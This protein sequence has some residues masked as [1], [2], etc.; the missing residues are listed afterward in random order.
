MQIIVKN[1][2]QGLIIFRHTTSLLNEIILRFVS[3]I[4]ASHVPNCDVHVRRF[5]N[6]QRQYMRVHR[7][8]FQPQ[9]TPNQTRFIRL[10]ILDHIFALHQ[11]CASNKCITPRGEW[12][13]C[14]YIVHSPASDPPSRTIQQWKYMV[15]L[16][17]WR[18]N[19][20]PHTSIWQILASFRH[21]Q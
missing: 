18:N 16:Y 14:I 10:S 5:I 13:L 1:L 3:N 2:N 6:S 19:I 11:W 17:S 8:F 21:P 7:S 20:H 12:S 15:Q 4:K 9:T